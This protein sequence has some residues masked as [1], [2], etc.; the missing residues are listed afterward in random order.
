MTIKKLK[1]LRRNQSVL[2]P[3]SIGAK[4]SDFVDSVARSIDRLTH[5]KSSPPICRGF[6][7]AN[8]KNKFSSPQIREIEIS[9]HGHTFHSAF[10][11]LLQNCNLN[12]SLVERKGKQSSLFTLTERVS[13]LKIQ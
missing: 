4:H 5:K 7:A 1:R 3:F 13:Q 12:G 2:N 6:E 9:V 10:F 8:I 11:F